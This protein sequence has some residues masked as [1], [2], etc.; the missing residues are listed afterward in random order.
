MVSALT[1]AQ[2]TLRKRKFYI[3][4][5]ASP[6]Y[7][8]RKLFN[9]DPGIGNFI[10][11]ERDSTEIPKIAYTF[12]LD[13][14]YKINKWIALSFGVQ[15]SLKGYQTKNQTLV[16][17]PPPRRGGATILVTPTNDHLTYNYNYIDIPLRVDIYLSK[18]KVAPF[19]TTG[20]ATN[21][22]LYSKNIS[23]LTYADGHRTSTSSSSTDNFSIIN[24]QFQLG[25]GVDIALKK[26]RLRILP[27]ARVSVL[28][29]N[30]DPIKEYLWSAGLGIS[31]LFGI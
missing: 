1:F 18:D 14:L 8:Y 10:K 25:A 19:I 31:Y 9:S 12:G 2:D 27:I 6:D 5:F 13:F 4:A 11:S 7:S 28:S 23:Y 26:S 24:P 15:Y 21:V 29:M 16:F 3:G 17:G 30:S 20:I 22:F